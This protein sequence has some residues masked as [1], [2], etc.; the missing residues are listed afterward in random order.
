MDARREGG[1]R[2]ARLAICIGAVLAG[3]IGA[4][5]HAGSDPAPEQAFSA[6]YR[7]CMASGD[8]AIGVTAAMLDCIGA[9]NA[10]QDARL[11]AAYKRAMARLDPAGK[12]RLRQ[13]ERAW[14]AQRD[15]RCEKAAASEGGGSMAGL[16]Y[17]D[18]VLQETARRAGWLEARGG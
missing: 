5:A 10:R 6:E 12:T 1:M 9:E 3:C 7:Q 18:C 11:N 16:L 15:S 4:G 2:P 14:I 13:S 17:A 8:A